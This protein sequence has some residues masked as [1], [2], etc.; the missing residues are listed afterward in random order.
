MATSK[1]KEILGLNTKELTALMRDL[2]IGSDHEDDFSLMMTAQDWTINEKIRAAVQY[3]GFDARQIIAQFYKKADENLIEDGSVPTLTCGDAV[4]HEKNDPKTD[5]LFF[6]NTF[7][8]RGNNISKA[9]LR[10]D[11]NAGNVLSRKARA[12]GISMDPN[13][14]K[15]VLSTKDLT[16]SRLA[17]AFAVCAATII[18]DKGVQGKLK[19]KLLGPLP[20]IMQHTIFASLIP[21]TSNFSESLRE[22]A[23]IL[24]MEMSIMLSL[25]KEKRKMMT[26]S[27]EDLLEVSNQYVDAAM[28]GSTMSDAVKMRILLKAGVIVVD[29]K[30]MKLSQ[31]T[32][33][34][35]ARLAGVRAKSR[36]TYSMAIEQLAVEEHSHFCVPNKLDNV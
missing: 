25:P 16:L 9:V 4:L 21:T 10:C 32:Q 17:Q 7:L 24:N 5:L 20:I 19:S 33:V 27:I 1:V 23:Q 13:K 36:L 29:N 30:V 2:G 11:S 26:K 6:I 14:N 34:V 8:E 31:E 18:L 22:V 35:V 3:M 12:Y 15:T 28:N